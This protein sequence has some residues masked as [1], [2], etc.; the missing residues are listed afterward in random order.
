MLGMGLNHPRSERP[1]GIASRKETAMRRLHHSWFRLVGFA[2]LLAGGVAGPLARPAAAQLASIDPLVNPVV[3]SRAW[4]PASGYGVVEANRS[5][6]A[7]RIVVGPVDPAP[8][9]SVD[10]RRVQ[11]ALAALHA[12]DLGGV[13]EAALET[14]VDAAQAW[15]QAS[16]YGALEATR[17][18]LARSLEP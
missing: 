5:G 11:A 7:D 4:D 1:S 10:P 8:G 13:Q 9:A 12:G 3:A 17:A 14:V 18:A 15:D 6:M 16:G 2:L